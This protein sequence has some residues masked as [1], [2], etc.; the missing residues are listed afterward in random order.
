M[1]SRSGSGENIRRIILHIGRHKS[2]T[3]SVQH[4]FHSNFALYEAR[5]ILYPKAGRAHNAVAHHELA[6]AVESKSDRRKFEAVSRELL[7]ELKPHHQTLIISS[8]TLQTLDRPD[9]LKALLKYFPNAQID[10]VCYFREFVDYM[11]SS[12]RQAVQNQSRAWTFEGF[13]KHRYPMRKFFKIWDAIGN[14]HCRWFHQDLLYKGDVVADLCH[15]MS[16][17]DGTPLDES[18]NISIGGNLLFLKLAD[19]VAGQTQFSYQQLAEL[20][21]RHPHLSKSFFISKA[22]CDKARKRNAYNKILFK[23]LGPVPL[24]FWNSNIAVPDQARLEADINLIRELVPDYDATL[25]RTYLGKAQ[26]WF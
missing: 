12:F 3:T 18:H 14:L 19:N 10:I 13:L 9:K 5:G 20:A 21:W 2:G 4:Y 25:S 8:E 15:L 16:L 17:M 26:D 23:K 22:R 11:A 7:D 24:R 6:S 1:T